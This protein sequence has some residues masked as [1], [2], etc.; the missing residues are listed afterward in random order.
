MIKQVYSPKHKKK[1]WLVD[2]RVNKKR[3]RATVFTKADAESVAHKLQHDA[4]LRKFGIRTVGQ[5]PALADLIARRLGVISN[6]REHTRATR[7]LTYLLD[8]LPRGVAVDQV[9]TSDLLLFVERRK[10]D[11]LSD[12]SV[13]RELNVISSTLHQAGQFYSQMEQWK[14]P[15][16]PTLKDRTM[17]RERYIDRGER[18]RIVEY[19]MSPQMEGEDPRAAIARHRTGLI[20]RFALASAM[21]HGEIDKLMW[22][23]VGKDRIKVLGTKTNKT[24]YVPITPVIG[25]ILAARKQA[26]KSR[27][28]FTAGGNT[29]PH[30]YRI[31]E[32][33]CN[34][35]DVPYGDDKPNGMRMHDCRHTATTDLLQAGIDLSTIQSITGHTDRTMILYYSHPTGESL[36]RAARALNAVADLKVA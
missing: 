5:S 18:A 25:E 6:K 35:V 32:D 23:H 19:L 15:R 31:L 10:K 4:S 9:T 1:V 17:R 33:A 28:V 16:I 34:A 27:Y 14:T 13:T 26:S 36:E 24:R 20:F 2:V 30:F 12:S 7:V 29:P 21:R 3:V 22:T 11:H 8:L